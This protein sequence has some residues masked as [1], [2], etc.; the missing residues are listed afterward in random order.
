MAAKSINVNFVF[1]NY[2]K[3]IVAS[4]TTAATGADLKAL[5]CQQWPDNV[6]KCDD[7]SRI[8]LICMGCGF[9]QDAEPIGNTT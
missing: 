2:E 6:P 8:R 4:T 7:R 5:L 9:L 1:A 3:R